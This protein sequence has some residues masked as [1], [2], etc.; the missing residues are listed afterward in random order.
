MKNLLFIS[1]L[2]FPFII[3]VSSCFDKKYFYLSILLY[4][5]GISAQ[6]GRGSIITCISSTLISIV[7]SLFLGM[8]IFK[9]NPWIDISTLSWIP[10]DIQREMYSEYFIQI[11][12]K[13]SLL[14]NGLVLFSIYFD[15]RRK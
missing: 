6:V 7:V 1:Y 3:V 2:P 12:C 8:A 10:V 13:A 4:I 5:I 15:N 11:L 14:L 9:E